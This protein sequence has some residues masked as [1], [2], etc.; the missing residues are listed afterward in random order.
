[1]K[2]LIALLLVI[3]SL[4]TLAS[5]IEDTEPQPTETGKPEITKLGDY[6]VS[7]EGCR[8][9][10]AYDD[11][12]IVIVKYKFI[13]YDD[14][15]AA[16]SYTIKDAVYQNGIGLNECYIADDSANYSSDNQ[17]KKV[18]KGATLDIEV[19]YVL[20]DTTTD[21]E[22]E[23]SELISFSD[24]KITKTLSIADSFV[25]GSPENEESESGT[26]A[27]FPT[28]DSN[29]EN[30]DTEAEPVE[31]NK[32]ENDRLG[33][34]GVSIESCRIARDYADNPIVIVKYKFTNYDDDAISFMAALTDTVYQNGVGLNQC[35]LADDSANYSTDN[36]TKEVKKN[37]S[38]D[39]EVAYKLNDTTTDIE[40]EVS[41][42]IS[43][44]DKKI[45]KVFSIA[46]SF[47]GEDV[48]SSDIG[49]A[50]SAIPEENPA[51]GSDRL[52]DYGVVIE[53]CRIARD[54]ADN[55]IVIVKYKFTNYDDDA[56]AFMWA[57]TD[58]VYQDGVGLNE[59]YFADDSANYSSDNQTKE[60]KKG[61][62]IE[63]EVAYVLNDT[64]TDIEVEISELLSFSDKKITKV[65]SID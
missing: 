50:N 26:E 48:A 43:F 54:Y 49:G 17:T 52:G 11:K 32:Q 6:G 55:P 16:F 60:V 18:K 14:D 2:K 39:V 30:N 8:V 33:D 25:D 46:S 29:T 45:T 27:T 12:P 51:T 34:Y 36:Q 10:R 59:C 47:G 61:S 3:V 22:V 20:N 13:N 7:I 62:T 57:F 9:A 4:I 28:F 42:W 5:C 19:A 24:K 15:E 41:K 23:V 1:M 31:P 21:V 63:V 65:F 58:I 53:S 35:Y 44:S 56:T 37:A 40:V 64:T 38:L